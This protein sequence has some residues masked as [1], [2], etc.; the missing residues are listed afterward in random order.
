MKSHRKLMERKNYTPLPSNK[1]ADILSSCHPDK[2]SDNMTI[3]P[4][5]PLPLSPRPVSCIEDHYNVIACRDLTLTNWSETFSIQPELYFLPR[6]VEEI[7]EILLLSKTN[8]K[9]LRVVG[10]CHSPSDIAFCTDYMMSLKL[11][12]RVLQISL[13]NLTVKVEAG[14]TLTKLNSELEKHDMA[15]PVL[16]SLSDVTVGG[17]INTAT[18][19]SGIGYQ[20]LS[21]Y[22]IE[23][24]LITC[25]GGVVKCS[26]EDKSDIFFSVLC[27]LGSLGVV[28]VVTLQCEP[29]Y[30]LYQR[31]T[32]STLDHVLDDLDDHLTQSEHFR[33]YWFPHTNHVS[34]DHIVRLPQGSVLPPAL[35]PLTKFID[36]ITTW[37]WNY[38]VGYHALEFAYYVSTMVPAITPWINRIWFFLQFSKETERIDRSPN[39]FNFDC[40]FKQHVYEVSIPVEKTQVVLTELRRYLDRHPHLFV[41]FPVEVRFVA[42]DDIYLSPAFGR[43]SCFINVIMYRPYGKTIEYNKWFSALDKIAREAGGRPHWAKVCSWF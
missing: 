30:L 3:N 19:G 10:R 24:E 20:V 11:M 25:S 29:S 35:P 38:A 15:L 6:D 21:A 27:G 5:N 4:M 9:R 42:A 13:E 43:N 31:R 8:R 26:K 2:N 33:F 40:L 14:I 17:A 36:N 34:L 37:F 23:L 28:T 12:N 22:V 39:I 1:T 41:H 16:P 18:H 7:R 32:P